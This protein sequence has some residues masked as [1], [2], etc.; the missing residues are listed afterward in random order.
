MTAEEVKDNISKQY[1]EDRERL[2]Q[3]PNPGNLYEIVIKYEIAQ[4]VENFWWSDDK[5]LSEIFE[6]LGTLEKPLDFMFEAYRDA[7]EDMWAK[8]R[9]TTYD[10]MRWNKDY[11]H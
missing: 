2:L 3:N 9:D 11:G 4:W 10:A 1:R 7:E 8:I 5:Y 6:Y